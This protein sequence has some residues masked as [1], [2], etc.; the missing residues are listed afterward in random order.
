MKYLL[1]IWACGL[2]TPEQLAVMRR[3]L[4]GW[5]EVE[6]AGCGLCPPVTRTGQAERSR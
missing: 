6:R 2:P 3:E 5:D 1:L 4:P